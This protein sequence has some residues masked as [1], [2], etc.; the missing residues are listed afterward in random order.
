MMFVS[1]PPMNAVINAPDQ[2]ISQTKHS[3][4]SSLQNF[5]KA[6]L[7]LGVLEGLIDGILILSEE[8]EWIHANDCAHRICQRLNA[9]SAPNR[10][11]KEIWRVCQ[12]LIHSRNLYPQRQVIM[13]AEIITDESVIYRVRV[14]WLK[15]DQIE[16]PC[17]LVT[18]EDRYQSLQNMAIAEIQKYD[19]TSREAEVWLLYRANHSYKEIADELYITLNTVKKHMKNIHAKRKVALDIEE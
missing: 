12:G 11:P 13:G 15:L 18:L 2:V 1:A 9:N 5:K 3:S 10:I 6:S 8:G 14:R 19:L 16:R 7:L 4:H 17:L